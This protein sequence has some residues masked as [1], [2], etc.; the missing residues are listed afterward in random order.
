M[1]RGFLPLF[2]T[3]LT[4]AFGVAV[5]MRLRSYG[6]NTTLVDAPLRANG[7]SVQETPMRTGH[8][9]SMATATIEELG[10]TTTSANATSTSSVSA[11]KQRYEELLRAGGPPATPVPPVPPQETLM[12]RMV[13]P[14]ASAL[15]ITRAKPAA[16]VAAAPP[17][18]RGQPQPGGRENSTGNGTS[19]KPREEKPREEPDPETDTIPPQLQAA[20]FTPAQVQDGAET[21]FSVAVIDNLSG[22]RSVSGVVSSPSGAL[23][24]FACQKEGQSNQFV[25][26][27]LV[28]QEAAEGIWTVKYLT[29]TDNANN[30]INLNQ[31]AGALPPSA[32]FRVVSKAPDATPP[33]LKSVYL[34]RRSMSAGEKNTVFVQAEDD[35][36]GVSL[37]SGVFVSPSKQAR[38]GFGCRPGAGGAWEC[39]VS[40]PTCLD[41][42]AWQL[43][44]IQVQDKANNMATFRADNQIVS[45]IALDISGDSCDSGPPTIRAL[46]VDPPVVSN[47]E[48][49]TIQ[50]AAVVADDSCGVASLS[51]QAIPVETQG[52]Q[53]IYFS[54]DP[55]PDGTN[56]YGRILV[57]RHAAKGTWTIGWIQALDKG[58][59]LK[60]YSSSDPVLA[61]VTFRVE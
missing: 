43:E 31:A 1:K 25:T 9:D 7:A 39:T 22:V 27:I 45:Q 32:S 51:G 56:F 19:E 40:P 29:L 28:P 52:G 46:S 55:S 3:V 14:I 16:T 2:F 33:V 49:G 36:S 61:R 12:E 59:N 23:Q 15:G 42:G 17:Q 18:V 54:F 35:K 8:P 50:I 58:H 20:Q 38:I 5:W 13:N 57:P 30:S 4:I 37:V 24:G 6:D 48:G 26:R 11:R 41:C 53:R 10:G 34:E 47:T 21:I 44:Q 60:A